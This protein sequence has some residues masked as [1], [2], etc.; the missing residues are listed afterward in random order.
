M[1]SHLTTYMA[2]F[3]SR[4]CFAKDAKGWHGAEEKARAR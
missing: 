3:G 1:E 2:S 4:E